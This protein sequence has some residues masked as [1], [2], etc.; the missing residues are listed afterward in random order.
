MHSPV[1]ISSCNPNKTLRLTIKA[2][3]KAEEKKRKNAALAP[4][5]SIETLTPP[6]ANG[7]QNLPTGE[8]SQ[9]AAPLNAHPTPP[10]E[11]LDPTEIE[12]AQTTVSA[13]APELTDQPAST[14]GIEQQ[15]AEDTTQDA[16]EQVDQEHLEPSNGEPAEEAIQNETAEMPT[17][18]A[19]D[20][21]GDQ[22]VGNAGL[23]DAAVSNNSNQ[24][25]NPMMAAMYMQ[26]MQMMGMP[27]MGMGMGMGMP[28]MFGG[29]GNVGMANTNPMNMNMNMMNMGMGIGMG[30]A[31]GGWNGQGR[32]GNFAYS[33]NG[34]NST[35]QYGHQNHQFPNQNYNNNYRGQGAY[36]GY[37]RGR[38]GF[39][40]RGGHYHQQQYGNQQGW[41]NNSSWNGAQQNMQDFSGPDIGTPNGSQ[42]GSFDDS[43]KSRTATQ[44]FEARGES[45]EAQI[46]TPDAS[47]VVSGQDTDARLGATQDTPQSY[48]HNQQTD[49]R[50][51][52]F[53]QGDPNMGPSEEFRN[54][55]A[56]EH[57]DV[58][59][60]L[61]AVSP[62]LNA[63]TG[64]KAMRMGFAVGN[65]VEDHK[66][67]NDERR[68]SSESVDRGAR[69]SI[70]R[71]I[72]QQESPP[73]EV[74]SNK[75]GRSSSRTSD[76]HHDARGNSQRRHRD[77]SHGDEERGNHSRRARDNRSRSPSTTGDRERHRSKKHRSD[78]ISSRSQR[79]SSR[80]GR[81]HRH[82]STSRDYSDRH[83]DK[84]SRKRSRRRDEDDTRRRD[85]EYEH[86]RESRRAERRGK[87]SKRSRRHRSKTPEMEDH[88]KRYE[89]TREKGHSG[90]DHKHNNA[91]DFADQLSDEVG[92]KI[93][94]S[95]NAAVAAEFG[96]AVP[97]GPKGDRGRDSANYDDRRESVQSVDPYALEREKRQ[98]ERLVREE[99]RRES[100]TLGKRSR[101]DDGGSNDGTFDA[102]TGP[103]SDSRSNTYHSSGHRSGGHRSGGKRNKRPR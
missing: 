41:T 94:G 63:P 35:G 54:Q 77:R 44:K 40:G 65:R 62:P 102:P 64:P 16:P 18:V 87:D 92:F 66:L 33:N 85:D 39:R 97:S 73:N 95:R 82:R 30:G 90:F 47:E 7:I 70:A 23:T 34:Y 53:E 3:L 1:E 26:N 27:G 37:G 51:N 28:N 96:S 21:G 89:T 17:E 6:P 75:R 52:G 100:A 71:D 32:N 78:D 69:V 49:A 48:E 2:F 22:P 67:E 38:G 79:D 68:R 57:T 61:R 36:R 86:E 60:S 98:K 19:T 74:P 31:A 24:H 43:A 58:A 10:Q 12:L 76:W 59:R 46:V 11:K 81:R 55:T 14:S 8:I 88:G 103:K 15:D 93:K 91:K 83:S 25:I 29:F 101:Y 99:K 5:K 45:S 13:A 42:V 80:E 84:Y 50:E 9:I 72:A 4:V 20:I 56:R